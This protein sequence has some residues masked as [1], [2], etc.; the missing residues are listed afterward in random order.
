MKIACGVPE[1]W[2]N[3][4][5]EEEY[6]RETEAAAYIR[7]STA[8]L[9]RWRRKGRINKQGTP[10]PKSYERGRQIW[11][12]RSDLDA[13]IASGQI[14]HFWLPPSLRSRTSETPAPVMAG[15]ATA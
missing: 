4:E 14:K 6:M 12:R 3:N 8:T 1:Y 9:R 2:S 7:V 13:W 10:P 5:R 15:P 11:Y